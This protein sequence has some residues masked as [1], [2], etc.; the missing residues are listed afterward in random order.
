MKSVNSFMV[1]KLIER[2]ITLYKTHTHNNNRIKKVSAECQIDTTIKSRKTLG[3]TKLIHLK[4]YIHIY[5]F[6]VT[7]SFCR[8]IQLVSQSICL[9]VNGWIWFLLFLFFVSIDCWKFL[10]CSLFIL[11]PHH[12]QFRFMSIRLAS[13]CCFNARK[14]E[15][16]HETQMTHRIYCIFFFSSGNVMH[17]ANSLCTVYCILFTI[18][19]QIYIQTKA[20]TNSKCD[21]W[22]NSNE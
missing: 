7:L 15:T 20:P 13:D 11:S 4:N 2:N 22:M 9:V 10:F 8:I 5:Y 18:A 12:N 3:K 16:I 1:F 17:N 14:T 6:D 19:Y 21:R